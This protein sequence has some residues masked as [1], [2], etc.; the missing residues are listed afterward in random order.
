[1]RRSQEGERV[2]ARSDRADHIPAPPEPVPAAGD[3]I[4]YRQADPERR[5]RIERAIREI[6]LRDAN[7]ILFFGSKAQ[8]KLTIVS[9]TMLEGVRNKDI[10]PAGTALSQMLSTLRGFNVADL[11][12]NK[13]R[14]LLDRLF[15]AGKP[16]AKVLRRYEEVRLQIDRIGDRL[17]AHKTELLGDIV[18]LDRLYDAN[19]EYF[20]HLADYI[21][22]GDEKLRELDEEILPALQHAVET[23]GDVLKA[24]ELRDMRAV[25]DDLERRVHDL[26]LTRQVAM[27]SL[28]SI[29]LVQQN[30]K[31]LISK[32]T[33]VLTNTVPLW[34][35]QLAQAVTIYRSREAGK[36]IKEA[37]DL[38]NELL[39]AN[40]ENLKQA[41]MEVRRQVERG[42][43]DIEAVKKANDL[44]IATIEESLQIADE[45][46][47]K[48]V[49][50]EQQLRVCEA[51]LRNT[52]AA[53]RS[54]T[55]RSPAH[56]R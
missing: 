3:V 47:R 50:A 6:D 8:E 38:T 37:T 28:P 31:S 23:T 26:K 7:S 13:E 54:R 5:A 36:T 53:A 20:H 45:G 1:M 48:R 29:R 24:Q 43:F 55:A 44:L 15:G 4:G 11:D 9:D 56:T 51:E 30:D 18:A 52:L 32:I 41:N 17:D 25:R 12:P 22:A 21:A 33:S 14:R 2:T 19:L 49:E 34:R 39:L 10:G 27:Q 40:A 42:A 35:T 46:K 16:I